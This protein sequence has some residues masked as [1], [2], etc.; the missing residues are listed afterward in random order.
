[1][2]S[3]WKRL[4]AVAVLLALT[5][6]WPGLAPAMMAP[7]NNSTIDIRVQSPDGTPLPG[8][9]V[10]L[11]SFNN[12]RPDAS[13]SRINVTDSSGIA[14]FSD[15]KISIGGGA[16]L[17][18]ALKDNASYVVL[19][20]SQGFLPGLVDQFNN[21]PPG[22][23]ASPSASTGTIT[24]TISSAGV[25]GV[26]EID[27]GVTHA[28]ASTLIFGQLGLQAG[29]GAVAYGITNTDSSGSGSFQ[30][31]NIAYSSAGTYQISAFD[32]ALGTSGKAAGHAVSVD[33]N[34]STPV[35]N[36]A[37]F[38]AFA[39]LDFNAGAP[40]VTAVNQTQQS[41][42]AGGLSVDGVVVD[43][44]TGNPVPYIHIDI[45]A[46]I[47]DAYNQNHDDFRG[48]N[49][50]QN[51]RFQF[52]NLVPGKN[53][54]ST[55]YGGC[56]GGTC[57][58]GQ[59]S[60]A[61]AAGFG[62][63]APGIND[64]FYASTSTVVK[65]TIGLFASTISSYT[66]FGVYVKDQFGNLF[67]QSGVGIFPDGASY[68]TA[69]GASCSGPYY[70]S[71]GLAS[72]NDNAA[73][74][75]LQVSGL[76]PGNYQ[77]NAWTPFGQ[78]NYNAGADG[79]SGN[80]TCSTSGNAAD[81]L[82]V[83][84][85][86]AAPH[87]LIYDIFGNLQTS[88]SSVTVT[89]NVSTG[90]SGLVKG[91]I[92]LPG[93]E[94]LS[95]SP[96]VLTLY[97]QCQ[98]G[99]ACSGGNFQTFN[100]L[101]TGP[102]I[103]YAIPV[104][105]GQAYWLNIGSAYWGAVFAGGGQNQV[106]L[107]STATATVNLTFQPA[108]RILGSLRKPDGSVYLPPKTQGGG[109][110]VNA[111]GQQSWG[112]AQV[113]N[114]GSFIIGG[115]LP[116]NYTLSVQNNGSGSFPYMVSVPAPLVAVSAG[117][118]SAQDAN[119]TDAVTVQ[120]QIDTTT[121]PLL[122][123]YANC[124]QNGHSDCP[125]ETWQGLALAKG[126]PLDSKLVTDLLGNGGS[127][128]G[129]FAYSVST[130]NVDACNGQYMTSP[131]MCSKPI[132]ANVVQG[133]TYDFYMMRHGGFDGANLAGNV[134][135][136][137]VIEFSTPSILIKQTL[138]TTPVYNGNS[139]ST[140]TV[141]ALSLVPSPSLSGVG[142]AT[143]KGK[144]TISNL[145]T[146]QQFTS[147]GGDFNKFLNFLPIAWV[148][149]STGTLKGAG[150]VVPTPSVEQA[151]DAQFQQA[152]ANGDYSAFSTIVSN[153]S[154]GV[155]YEIR[156]LTAGKT[157][158]LVVTSPNY[159]PY[160]T[161]VTM[162]VA[163]TTTTVDADLDLNPGETL[164]GVVQSSMSVAIKGAQV[165]IKAS[166]YT[167]KTL[168]TGSSGGF[169]VRGL[170]AGQ[171]QVTVVAAGYAQAAQNVSVT[172]SG[173]ATVPTF[174]LKAADA[175]ITG[176]VYTNNPVCPAGSSGCA[177]F[178][179]T[180]IQGASVLAYDDTLNS[181][182]PT[183]VLPL[184]RAVS[185]TSGFYSLDGLQSGETYKIFVNSPGYLISNATVTAAVGIS[186]GADFSLK[187][188]PLD[189]NVFGQPSGT[190]YEFEITNYKQFS[191]G[192]VWVGPSPFSKSV[193]TDV[194]NLFMEKPDAQGVT[195]LVLDY[196][197]SQLTTGQTYILHLEAT[198]NDPQAPVVVKDL[199]FGL[200][201]PHNACQSI[202]QA[203]I[204]DDKGVNAQG[205][206][207][208]SLPLDISGGGGGNSTALVLPAGGLIPS[209]STAV[210]SEC[211]SETDASASTQAAVLSSTAAFASG[212]YQVTLSSVNYTQKGVDLTL[213]Y[214]KTGASLNDLAV[215]TYDSASAQWK[216]VPGVQ[217]L[218][219]VQ[220]TIQVKGLKSLSSV[221]SLRGASSLMAV[222]DGRSYRPAASSGASDTGLFAVMRPSQLAGSFTGTTV[223]IYN[224]PNPFSLQSKSVALNT[225]S[226]NNCSNTTP[227]MQTDGTVIKFEL[228]AL[229]S[230][231]AT[232]RIY[233]LS[234]RLVKNID[235]GDVTA[236]KCYY[237][238]WDGR[239]HN[240]LQ[241][242][243]GVYYGILTVGGSG[244]H[245]ATFKMAV[246][247]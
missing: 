86:T 216:S 5:A 71:P 31:Y 23:V 93:V 16:Y 114:D 145:I 246:I 55:V 82:R 129:S 49:T 234:G 34:A 63:A 170:A 88:G 40:P 65:P 122:G 131:G 107:R 242:A 72:L 24:V 164:S 232:I 202:D 61:M 229:V 27:I 217:T 108:G 47:T 99:Q 3:A 147:L 207:N 241:V 177:A 32:P 56:S 135:P 138:A 119:L 13:A 97:P 127:F 149:D 30:F 25:T 235:Q 51:G 157:Y 76:P 20:S 133:A 176:T 103:D 161:S 75:Y 165:S 22:F 136:Y 194:S 74:G 7:A 50:D 10:A 14:N 186:T 44:A 137:F 91:S 19:V 197:L 210:P 184:Y 220:G 206:P 35:I 128:P 120:P 156:G 104:S 150:L 173:S 18:G 205:L 169:S 199:P 124:P 8:V 166:G 46:H 94:D 115:L 21:N 123:I 77:L 64:F 227:S 15:P 175:V 26:G 117:K 155:G 39:A 6:A 41:G 121:L 58:Q 201:L 181:N 153:W 168:A 96:I 2:R 225:T 28:S 192:K 134:R 209:V 236:G 109:L 211:M 171:Y 92:T 4:P 172:G 80:G 233:T 183:A 160:K 29:G 238:T 33:L 179:K 78:A 222:T 53:Y 106:D 68:Q 73:T 84:I 167:T 198:P 70:N 151:G 228:P 239:N 245:S 230:G 52:F 148:Y 90:S 174:S 142:Q 59:A 187:P 98:N 154:G 223:R 219:P 226:S 237:S 57:Y 196:P 67:P 110:S 112:Y 85:T 1:M 204:G 190:D 132:A 62:T 212:V 240:G 193:S 188:K 17:G 66:A 213:S 79:K 203:L 224:F 152:V 140:T 116:G 162:G 36:T 83:T 143:L 37:N 243:N 125:P 158:T 111:G 200:D 89:V 81:D 45:A 221:L 159:P 126:T 102:T 43:T 130:G 214:D 95:Q 244:G 42:S 87:V 146:N 105:S 189:V 69:G 141:Q 11:M 54:Y 139:Q 48:T 163:G 191:K 144:V 178:G 38:P 60:T 100:A 215:Y 12:G 113:S 182:S 231:H 118:D 247:K 9:H 180:V 101:S 208:N 218:D 185:S 195:Q